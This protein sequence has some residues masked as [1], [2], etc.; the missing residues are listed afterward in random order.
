MTKEM[1]CSLVVEIG[2]TVVFVLIVLIYFPTCTSEFYFFCFTAYFQATVH[3]TVGNKR[4]LV[5][6]SA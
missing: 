4:R 2:F 1:F 6:A 3:S 5:N